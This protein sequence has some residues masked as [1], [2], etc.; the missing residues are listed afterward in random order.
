M[1]S[2]SENN[3][4]SVVRFGVLMAA[5]MMINIVTCMIDYRRV[6]DW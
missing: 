4:F 1:I 3:I 5:N 2:E 6:L